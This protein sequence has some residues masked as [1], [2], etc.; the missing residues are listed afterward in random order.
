MKK[1]V[2]NLVRMHFPESL[3]SSILCIWMKTRARTPPSLSFSLKC[4]RREKIPLIIGNKCRVYIMIIA[5]SLISFRILLF[6]F[7]GSARTTSRK[8][9]LDTFS[10]HHGER[11][12]TWCWKTRLWWTFLDQVTEREVQRVERSDLTLIVIIT[13]FHWVRESWVTSKKQKNRRRKGL[14][15]LRGKMGVFTLCDKKSHTQEGGSRKRHTQERQEN[16]N[17]LL[18]CS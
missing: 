12:V 11:V 14:A 3:A 13:T 17:V 5:S 15:D 10:F 7:E 1:S 2:T 4:K 8:K 16:K 6:L 18:T 9:R